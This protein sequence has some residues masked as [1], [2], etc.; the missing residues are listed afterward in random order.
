MKQV[1]QSYK[2][3]ELELAEV[4]TPTQARQGQVLVATRASLVSVGTEKYMLQLASKS[5]LRKAL[6]RPDLVRQVIAKAQAEG[7]L[8]ACCP[9]MLSSSTIKDSG[10]TPDEEGRTLA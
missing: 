6:A 9:A 1:I 8:E 2:P 10:E 3:G 4:P 7:I 5:L